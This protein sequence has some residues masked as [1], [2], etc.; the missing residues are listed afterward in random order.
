MRR[1]TTATRAVNLFGPGKDGYKDGNLAL[2]V[3]PTDLNADAFNQL[4][5]EI[6][7]VIEDAGVVLNGAI[8]TQ[9][10]DVIRV[11]TTGRLL[12]ATVNNIPGTYTFTPDPA[13]KF[14]EVEGVSG[15][16]GGGGTT[17]TAAG[18]QAVAAGGAGG[19]YFRKFIVAGFAGVSYTVGAGGNGGVGGT[20]GSAGGTSS[21]GAVVGASGG[22][23]GQA[24]GA[25]AVT[26][27]SPTFPSGTGIPGAT[28]SGTAD[29]RSSGGPGMYGLYAPVN[30][31]SGAGGESYFG[32]GA[33]G[34]D[35]QQNSSSAGFNAASIGGGGGGA[36]NAPSAGAKN[37]GKGGDGAI[38]I[39]EYT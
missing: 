31:V 12:E 13:T 30:Y 29:F 26:G 21:F 15:G 16:G 22:G 2:G 6:C 38:I 35:F 10:R 7:N 27:T 18:Q 3:A 37:G 5:E 25:V 19:N 32:P 8:M 23:G 11:K 1:I 17:A 9:L 24:G 4:Q 20:Q 34:I 39:R 36:L 28:T 14:I 33:I